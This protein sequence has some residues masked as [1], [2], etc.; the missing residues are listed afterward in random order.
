[1]AEL[2]QLKRRAE[3]PVCMLQI[4]EQPISLDSFIHHDLG[5]AAA[6]LD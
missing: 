6:S 4:C 5:V 1:M 2:T 3:D